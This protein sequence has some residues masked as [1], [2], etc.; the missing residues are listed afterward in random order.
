[1]GISTNPAT[2]SE[3]IP[4]SFCHTYR[5]LRREGA[6]RNVNIMCPRYGSLASA[7]LAI[8]CVGGHRRGD[9][10]LVG[11][12]RG[13]AHLRNLGR[14]GRIANCGSDLESKEQ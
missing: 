1:M 9:A 4:R 3:S 2:A 7:I 12:R 5:V 14:R 10:R 13:L 8:Q 6:E 11:L